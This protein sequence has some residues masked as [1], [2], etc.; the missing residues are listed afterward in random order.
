MTSISKPAENK[1]AAKDSSQT[2]TESDVSLSHNSTTVSNGSVELDSISQDTT[3][4]IDNEIETASGESGIIVE[5]DSATSDVSV[6]I[7]QNTDNVSEV[8][9]RLLSDESLIAEQSGSYTAGDTVQF[10]GLN[11]S[12]NTS[13]LIVCYNTGSDFDRGHYNSGNFPYVGADSAIIDGWRG[14]F[15][16]Q[17]PFCLNNLRTENDVVP[18]TSGTVY[19]EW[20]KPP[21]IYRWDAAT[22]QKTLDGETVDV[23]IEES[24]DGGSTWT[25]IAGPISRGQQIPALPDSKC[26]F[27]VDFSR[28][29]TANTPSLHSIYR[30]W[31]V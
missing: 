28:G 3:R 23:Y 19:V 20:S 6:D 25:E 17:E 16:V 2:F 26:R 14:G 7:S 12:A 31:V 9:I 29:D 24:S 18:Q 10:T 21:D 22:F 1:I 13:Y 11:L 30:R 15:D 8:R 5:F 4:D 27:R